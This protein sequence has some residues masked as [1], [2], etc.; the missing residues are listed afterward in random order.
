MKMRRVVV[1]Q[2]TSLWLL[3]RRRQS[4][5]VAGLAIL[6]VAAKVVAAESDGAP[7]VEAVHSAV[8]H[9]V[10]MST[11]GV[12]CCGVLVVVIDLILKIVV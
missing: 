11:I 2:L 3:R 1:A 5:C 6:H 12:V 8:V 4:S 7:R 10:W 9:A